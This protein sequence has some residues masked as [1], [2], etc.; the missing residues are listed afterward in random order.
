MRVMAENGVLW[1]FKEFNEYFRKQY[2][3]K[4]YHE[5]QR[6]MNTLKINIIIRTVEDHVFKDPKQFD[7]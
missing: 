7:V 3:D 1:S 2:H 5:S 4:E 6:K